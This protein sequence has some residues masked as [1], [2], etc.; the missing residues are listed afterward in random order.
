MYKKTTELETSRISIMCPDMN[1]DVFRLHAQRD[2]YK[3]S[4]DTPLRQRRYK[5]AMP[6]MMVTV[7]PTKL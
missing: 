7:D 4:T 1:S 5:M 3:G 6:K 2:A